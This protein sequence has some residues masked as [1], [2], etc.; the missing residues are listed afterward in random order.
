MRHFP[1][2][3]AITLFAAT[4]SAQTPTPADG[5]DATFADPLLDNFVGVWHVVRKFGDG[6]TAENTVR[7]G[8]VLN[9]QFLEL[10]YVD[11]ATPAQYEAL[12]FIGFD[13]KTQRYVLHWI[14]VF[15]GRAS[16]TIGYGTPDEAAH[17]IYFT[18]NNSDGQI[19]NC[20]AFDPATKTWSSVMRQKSKGPWSLFAEDKFT[21]IASKP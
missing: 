3:V 7:I 17:A 11:V 8:W 9:H 5:R 4:M 21:R 16:E 1:L 13:H 18:F 19:M 15:G 6:R 20:Y 12:A 14:D 2:L 10:H